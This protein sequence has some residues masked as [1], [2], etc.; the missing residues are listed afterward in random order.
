MSMNIRSLG[1]LVA[2]VVLSVSGLDR[3]WAREEIKFKGVID[4]LNIKVVKAA[5]KKAGKKKKR[6]KGKKASI[7][8]GQKTIEIVFNVNP[9]VPKGAV[10]QFELEYRGLPFGQPKSYKFKSE[11]RSNLKLSWT[12][13][14]RLPVDE[15]R[16]WTRMPLALQSG[17]VKKIIKKNTKAWPE[18]DEPWVWY[19]LDKPFQIG[20]QADA[21]IEK[22]EIKKYFHESCDKFVELNG[23]FIDLCDSV[24]AGEKFVSGGSLSTEEL[25]EAVIAWMKKMADIQKSNAGYRQ[26]EPGLYSKSEKAHYLLKTLGQMVAKRCYRQKLKGTLLKYKLGMKDLKLVGVEGFD[27]GYRGRTQVQDLQR[28][29]EDLAE[30]TGFI[31]DLEGEEESDEE[32][33]G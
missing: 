29:Y 33:A 12:P 26:K 4:I 28:K 24:E 10:L 18:K 1:C 23:E 13:N 8:K 16:L 32:T 3:A 5:G 27:S 22:E 2:I 25:S 9:D 7:R 31:E 14:S 19:Y 21:A 30:L 17:S 11:N 6:K 20:T 15:Y